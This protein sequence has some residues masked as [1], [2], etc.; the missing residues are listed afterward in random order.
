M[1][2][3]HRHPAYVNLQVWPCEHTHLN[4]NRILGNAVHIFVTNPIYHNSWALF[5][6]TGIYWFKTKMW[7]FPPQI[8]HW[9]FWK[10]LW[11]Y[12]GLMPPTDIPVKNCASLLIWLKEQ[13][14][15]TGVSAEDPETDR[16][17]HFFET[18]YTTPSLNLNLSRHVC[19][20]FLLI[21]YHWL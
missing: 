20:C 15:Y 18:A 4:P 8:N 14:T 9:H 3:P 17:V 16:A 5:I 19:S 2:W 13:H 6:Q 1:R 10:H 12:Y 7:C 11:Y 21:S